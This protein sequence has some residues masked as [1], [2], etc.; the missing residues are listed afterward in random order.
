MS[1]RYKFFAHRQCE[2]FPCHKG[3][4][5]DR[6]NCLFCYCPLYLVPD[7][8]GDFTRLGDGNK[9]CSHCLLPHDPDRYDQVVRILQKKVFKPFDKK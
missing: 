7:C 6:F 2:F 8:S 4:D 9:D 1:C 3:A 5:P